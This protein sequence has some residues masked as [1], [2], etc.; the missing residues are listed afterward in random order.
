MVEASEQ[1]ELRR[2]AQILMENRWVSR[3]E[4]PDEYLL[5][6]RNEKALRQFF[7]EKCGWPLL[8]TANF[9]KLEKIPANPWGFM[10]IAA[11]QSIEDYVLLACVMAFLEEYESG[12][13]FLLGDLAEALLAYYP[14][15]AHTPRLNWESYNWRKSLI[16]VLNFLAEEGIINIV[17]DESTGFISQGFNADGAIAGEALYEVTNLARYFLRSFPKELSDYVSWQDLL[18]ADYVTDTNEE[19]RSLRHRR[20]RIYR[21]LLLKPVFYR[22]GE[23]EADFAYLRNRRGRLENIIQDWFG[24]HLELY[25]N[26]VMAVSHEQST[27]FNDVFPVRFRGIHDI[28]LHLSHYL[29]ELSPEQVKQPMTINQWQGHLEQLSKNTKAGWTKEYREM[30]LKRLSERL[31]EEMTSWGMVKVDEDGLITV[32]SALF[33]HEGVYPADYTGKK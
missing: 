4:M 31:L 8:V 9:Y 25:Q 2:G 11:M 16:R 21:E 13:Q 29:R 18:E 23:Y 6:R 12:G 28:I 24:L 32:Q 33:R 14:Q 26:G 17:D 1:E 20:N 3:R 22:Q 7:R 19:A 5:I 10:G 15:E 30:S 27:W